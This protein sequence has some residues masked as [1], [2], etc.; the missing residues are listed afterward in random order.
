VVVGQEILVTLQMDIQTGLAV[1]Q[2]MTVSQV[3]IAA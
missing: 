3:Q 2:I 1:N